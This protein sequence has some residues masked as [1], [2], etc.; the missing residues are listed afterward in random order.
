MAK[1]KFCTA[2]MFYVRLTKCKTSYTAVC[3]DCSLLRCYAVQFSRRVTPL[4]RNC[5]LH[6][7]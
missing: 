5:C 3:Q 1:L 2:A 7:S 4:W 6:P